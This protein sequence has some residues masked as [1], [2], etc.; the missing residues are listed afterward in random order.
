MNFNG[1][2]AQKNVESHC[3]HPKLTMCFRA[4]CL[5]D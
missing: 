1:N 4:Q 5:P 3:F 2:Y